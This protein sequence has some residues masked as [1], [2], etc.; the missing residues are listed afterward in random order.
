MS[1]HLEARHTG[2]FDI[3]EKDVGF[4]FENSGNGLHRIGAGAG[5]LHPLG[6]GEHPLQAF[7]RERFVVNQKC[8]HGHGSDTSDSLRNRQDQ[9]I[10]PAHALQYERRPVS[11]QRRQPVLEIVEPVA[12]RRRFKLEL[13]A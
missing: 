13:R 5:N 7:Q 1:Q 11:E 3:E 8:P 10:A 2:H 6:D 9:V 12:R 4:C